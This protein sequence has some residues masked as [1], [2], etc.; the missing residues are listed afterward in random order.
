MAIIFYE[1]K[2]A[3]KILGGDFEGRPSFYD[4]CIVSRYLKKL[5]KNKTQIYDD[6][7][8]L[9]ESIDPDFN[10][11]LSQH[12]IKRAIDTIDKYNLRETSPIRV[13]KNEINSIT[14][15]FDDF[16]EQKVLFIMLVLSKFK[17]KKDHIKNRKPSK[18]DGNYYVSE[19]LTS[20]LKLSKVYLSKKERHEMLYRLEQSGMIRTTLNGSF[21][22]MFVD[23]NP[24]SKVE[25]VIV[26]L[27]NIESFFPYYCVV[28]GKRYERKPYDKNH[29]CDPCSQEERRKAKQEAMANARTLTERVTSRR[30]SEFD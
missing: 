14:K 21:Q 5:G 28:C 7:V 17:H 13:T 11:V 10:E 4:L 8:D 24:R 26:D 3:K 30:M 20:I 19:K 27:E 12:Y 16:K 9:Y 15:A 22:I 1:E 6:I 18:Y 25:V 29:M 23:E 2:H